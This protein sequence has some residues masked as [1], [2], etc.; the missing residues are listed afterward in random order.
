MSL[1]PDGST[2]DFR[3]LFESVPGLYLVLTSDLTIVAVSDAYLKATK[4]MRP[5]I[6]G[7]RIF[8][9]FPDNPADDTATGTTNLR[10]SL[11][12]VLDRRTTD[13]MAVQ[14]YDIRLP[15]AEG[16]GF[17]ERHWSPVNSPVFAADGTV[18]A[19][20]HRVE[21]VT[22]F[23]HLQA[24]Q[25]E[26]Q[27][28]TEALRARASAMESEI[29]QRAQ[30]IARANRD[31]RQEIERRQAIQTQLEQESRKLHDTNEALVALQHSR[32]MLANM[33]VHDLRNP[34]TASI[35][36]LDMLLMK[37][38]GQAN[39][40]VRYAQGALD[41]NMV[42]M[43]MINGIL[44]VMRMEDGRM[45]VRL[46]S[47]DIVTLVAEK[48]QQYQ[49]TA[50]NSGLALTYDGPTHLTVVTDGGLLSRVVDNLVVNAIKHTP[51]G[52]AITVAA[53][54]G[55]APGA[56][57]IEVRDTGEG[58]APAD[59][60]RLFQKYGRVEGQ[61]MGRRYDT[62]LGLVFCRMAVD[63]LRGDITVAS[64]LGAGS[65]FTITLGEPQSS[66][67]T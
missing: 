59:C 33:I 53:R 29:Y 5:D 14:K 48:L 15:D 65:T 56:L 50:A 9:V 4:T 55:S 58:I 45:P 22:E 52:G 20:I 11:Q 24:V 13:I 40:L 26:R 54:P 38:H 1:P 6:L 36:Y 7:R 10:A 41:V 63:L 30:D 8:D 49:P 2:L 67:K 19:I 51:P 21:D 62:G 37:L 16:G 12:R 61:T 46:A 18:S 25:R 31:L 66:A 32:D 64:K 44:D 35:G 57:V 60:E 39:D 17:V 34:L 3:V 43:D 42:M 28:M 23:V 27:E 47:T